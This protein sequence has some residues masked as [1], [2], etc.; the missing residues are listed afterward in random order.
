MWNAFLVEHVFN[1]SVCFLLPLNYPEGGDELTRLSLYEA[2]CLVH[3][4][5]QLLTQGALVEV[6]IV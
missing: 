6:V 1:E 3:N 2:S 5:P 4:Q